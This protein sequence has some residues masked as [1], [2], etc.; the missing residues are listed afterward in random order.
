MKMGS[1]TETERPCGRPFRRTENVYGKAPG[2]DIEAVS[3]N[4]H[5][6]GSFGTSSPRGNSV[7]K[8]VR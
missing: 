6:G 5:R 2:T 7:G 3:R 1:G 4:D 8:L